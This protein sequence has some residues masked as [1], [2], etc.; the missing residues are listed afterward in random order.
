MKSQHEGK[1]GSLFSS[2]LL[3]KGFW[4]N[5][6]QLKYP[7]LSKH[8]NIFTYHILKTLTKRLLETVFLK[9][10]ERA[11]YFYTAVEERP[12]TDN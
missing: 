6:E 5:S 8:R 4:F 9:C 7:E 3:S 12:R 11:I 10:V 2:E 1:F